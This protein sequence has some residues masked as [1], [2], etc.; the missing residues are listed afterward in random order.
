[1]L[2]VRL[3]RVRKGRDTSTDSSGEK[4]R[5]NWVDK[6]GLLVAVASVG[7]AVVALS[8]NSGTGGKGH[9]NLKVVDVV[10]RD[11]GKGPEPRPHLEVIVHNTGNRLSVVDQVSFRIRHVYELGRCAS[12]DDIPLSATYGVSLP[13]EAKPGEIVKA[14]LHQ[15]VDADEADRFGIN[16]S[17]EAPEDKSSGSIYLFEADVALSTDDRHQSLSIGNL[18]ISL[19]QIPYP[20]EYYWSGE[21]AELLHGFVVNDPVYAQGLRR[22]SM[23]CWLSNTKTLRRAFSYKSLRSRSLEAISQDLVTPV[24]TALE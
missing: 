19:P 9:P 11:V 17:V 14:P 16:L 7:V 15:Q 12:Q 21:T 4:G 5:P 20:G 10:I 18:L 22:V 6:A 8:G 13:A 24:V 2:G 1:V 23:P 3:R